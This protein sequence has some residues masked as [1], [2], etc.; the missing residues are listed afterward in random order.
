MAL[1]KTKHQLSTPTQATKDNSSDSG[2][3][4]HLAPRL[5]QLTKP[6]RALLALGL[7]A[8]ILGS[9]INLLFPFLIRE[10]L[11]GSHGL[12][13]S[14]DLALLTTVLIVLFVIQSVVFYLR[15]YAFVVVG[16]RMVQDLRS[17]LFKAIIN[18]DIAFF[19]RSRVG[20]LLSRLASDTQ[21]I[22]RALTINISVALRYL[23]Q[24]V[25]GT[26]LMAIISPRLTLAI[27]LV[28]PSIIVASSYWGKRLRLLS[29][30]LQSELGEAS[31]VAEEAMSAVR[32]VRVFAGGNYEAARYDAHLN[33]ALKTGEIR[34]KFAAFF[35]SF[36][37][38]LIHSS[39]AFVVWYGGNMV[40]Q[41]QL[42]VGDLSGFLLYC[43]IVAV[44]IGFLANVWDEFMQAIGASERVFEILDSE[45]T[46]SSPENPSPINTNAGVSLHFENVS[47]SYPSRSTVPVLNN[48][49]FELKPGQ[50]LA[51]VGPSGAGKSTVA[52]LIPRFY[53][54]NSGQ[55]RFCG[56]PLK[57][58]DLDQLRSKIS[59]VS[60]S[61]EIFSVSIGENIKYGRTNATQAEIQQAATAAN[62][63]DFI[64]G[65]PSGYDTLVGDKGIQ[66]SGGQKQR[67][68]IARA[69]LKKPEFLILDEA[70]SSLDSENE[71]LI[72]EALARLTKGRTTLVIAHRLS[73]VQHA[74]QVLV[75]K[76][77]SII[78]RGTH[79]TLL[80]E[81][82]LYQTLVEH[83]LL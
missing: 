46:V 56:I 77:G 81:S 82:G 40:L 66:L 52:A 32:S 80:N 41:K 29:K 16:Y 13:I 1:P 17:Q 74:D 34:T 43:V 5:L 50:T 65:L 53:D 55:I 37:V 48:I 68:A 4:R 73:T 54:P 25:G 39:I 12:D 75:L 38:F 64:S 42:T 59:T 28:I 33:Q 18:Q 70:T 76:S 3:V 36:M 45:A 6:H 49:S 62:L 79:Q 51:L 19:D 11:N 31:V 71:K 83:Q 8:L 23:L 27:I 58:L 44:S 61:T 15:H 30:K 14:R 2:R 7:V 60:Q 20:D 47:F 35:T 22:Q 63:D 57:E 67:L 21:L 24:V 9:G 10:A 26:I 78:Q 72:Q 69:L